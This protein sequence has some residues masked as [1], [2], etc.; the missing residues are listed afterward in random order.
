MFQSLIHL[1]EISV[2]KLKEISVFKLEYN[3]SFSHLNIQL[4][5]SSLLLK[6]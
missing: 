2:Y 3:F 5:R 1:E 6:S 4:C